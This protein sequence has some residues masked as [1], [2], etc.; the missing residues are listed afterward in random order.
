MSPVIALTDLEAK[1]IAGAN[2]ALSWIKADG[3][4][5][6]ASAAKRAEIMY[7]A[8]GLSESLDDY[9]ALTA[10]ETHPASLFPDL[11]HHQDNAMETALDRVRED[12]TRWTAAL[13][14]LAQAAEDTARAREEEMAA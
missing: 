9:A 12:I 6:P 2:A 11:C 10:G 14:E 8:G 5:W 7:H 4:P 3:F 1:A 13:I